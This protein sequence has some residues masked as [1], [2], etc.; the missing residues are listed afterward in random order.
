MTKPQEIDII[1]AVELG[2]NCTIGDINTTYNP[3]GSYIIK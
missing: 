3:K 1:E 2:D